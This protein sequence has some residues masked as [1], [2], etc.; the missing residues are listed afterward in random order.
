MGTAAMAGAAVALLGA[1][2]A[3]A[4]LPSR[5]QAELVDAQHPAETTQ[6]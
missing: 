3:L 1:V 2:V 5:P 4:F 6:P